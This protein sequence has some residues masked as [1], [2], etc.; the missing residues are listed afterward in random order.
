M[1][2]FGLG[3]IVLLIAALSGCARQPEQPAVNLAAE[4]AA[5]RATDAQ[6][7]A[8][9]KA[10]DA[11]KAASYWSD[12]A[13]IFP[14]EAAPIIGKQAIRAYVAGAFASPEFSINWTTDKVVVSSSGD[15]A[16]ATGT[17]QFTFRAPD[18]KVV[19]QKTHGVVVW[20]KQPDGAWKAVIDIWN[21]AS[22]AKSL[23]ASAQ[24]K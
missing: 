17:D 1:R 6:W 23:D 14:P 10:R 12:D 7:L 4:E 5:I 15:M 11:E 19:S 22:P 13:T 16:Y 9:G 8:A 18:N 20:K 24:G 3:F 2:T 21:A